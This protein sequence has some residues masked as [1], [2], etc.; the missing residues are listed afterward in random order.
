MPSRWPWPRCGL[1]Q[2][3]PRASLARFH[4]TSPL[5]DVVQLEGVLSGEIGVMGKDIHLKAFKE[6]FTCGSAPRARTFLREHSA[7]FK[8]VL[9]NVAEKHTRGLSV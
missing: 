1:P 7:L 2:L 4:G 6:S 8:R 5:G 9:I 3:P